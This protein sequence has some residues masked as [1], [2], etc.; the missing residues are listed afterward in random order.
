M[1]SPKIDTV[2]PDG[3]LRRNEQGAD[4]IETG[5]QMRGRAG[6]PTPLPRDPRRVGLCVRVRILAVHQLE[7]EQVL[8]GELIARADAIPAAELLAEPDPAVIIVDRLP[9]VGVQRPRIDIR[10]VRQLGGIGVQEPLHYG[11]SRGIG[12]QG[13]RS[14]G[15]GTSA[16]PFTLPRIRACPLRG[17]RRPRAIAAQRH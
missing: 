12:N 14:F 5:A 17:K 10:P 16:F 11:A 3:A 4:S 15:R 9:R 8:R 6:V 2:G 1:V 13:V 7:R